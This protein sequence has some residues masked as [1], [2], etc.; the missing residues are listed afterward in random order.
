M[1]IKTKLIACLSILAV[2]LVA[3][4]GFA[5]YALEE[6]SKLANSIVADRVLPMGQ[7][8]KVA[9]SY[10]VSIVDTVHKTR[11]G[12]LSPDDG[13]RNIETALHAID[14]YWREY[15]ATQLTSEEIQIANR[16]ETARADTDQKL[17]SLLVLIQ[18]ADLKALGT[19]A[20]KEL[21]PTIDPLG[22]QIDKLIN[23]Q[24]RVAGETLQ[25]GNRMKETLTAVMV[26]L[27][28]AGIAVIA[29]SV[30][31]VLA[32]VV[33]PLIR[34]TDAMS[35]LA[36]GKLDVVLYGEG[37]KDEIGTMASAVAVFRDG[38][39]ERLRLESEAEAN[40]SLSE[41]ERIERDR[42]RTTEAEEVRFAVDTLKQGLEQLAD[43]NLAHRINATFAEHLDGL[44]T[45]FNGS[46]NR[47]EETLRTVGQ[48][49]QAIA[50]GSN[51][52]MAA[53]NDLSKRTEQQAA[54]V[55][56][57]AAAL[58]QI[59]TTVADSSKRAHEVG[60][61][62]AQT[63]ESAEHSGNVVRKAMMAMSE[64]ERSS[65]EIVSIIGVI[66]DIAFQTNLLALNA[67][68]EAARA[69]EAGKG[70]AVVAQ[71]V[72]ELAQRSATAAKKIKSLINTSGEQV[73]NGVELVA[74]TGKALTEIVSQVQNVSVNVTA[75]VEA[76]REQAIGLKEINTAVNTMD[77]GTQQN[78]ALVEQSTAASNSLAREAETLFGLIGRFKVGSTASGKPDLRLAAVSS[79]RASVLSPAKKLLG[80]VENAFRGNT[81]IAAKDWEDF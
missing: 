57:T 9:D 62:V 59:T 72:R 24:L 71:E 50:A 44:R 14:D 6:E 48:N 42:I 25:I 15:R 4:A 20:D 11:A 53:A 73:R 1:S 52:I 8:K 3:M 69:G 70:F 67:G 76:A 27:A 63:R 49:A 74:E 32:A 23:L 51:Q 43:G 61:L 10:A 45:D 21:Y 81:A 79:Q 16:F 46:V 39:Q 60:N 78:A 41:R 47:L 35:E 64:I 36:A 7:L 80:K 55:E 2:A 30:W 77:Q 12:S 33:R 5:F 13:K 68:V 22:G 65:N 54:S 75:I 34:M 29:L 37:R 31:T 17:K 28:L 58:E 26:T 40:H 38:A 56:E 66:D 19:Y 18:T